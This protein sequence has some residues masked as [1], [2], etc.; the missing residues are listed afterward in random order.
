MGSRLDLDF[1]ECWLGILSRLNRLGVSSNVSSESLI[2]TQTLKWPH[3]DVRL[4]G[5]VISAQRL[6][7]SEDTHL[8][9]ASCVKRFFWCSARGRR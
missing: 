6:S 5:I 3:H 4:L 1:P 7:V 8:Y 9:S 2:I